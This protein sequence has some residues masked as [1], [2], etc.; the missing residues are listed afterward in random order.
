[1][2]LF[3]PLKKGNVLRINLITLLLGILGGVMPLCAAQLG[4]QWK[5]HPAA[6]LGTSA[7]GSQVQKM[8]ATERY[9]YLVTRGRL[10]DRSKGGKN[11][12]LT[13]EF[14]DL[15]RIDRQH[16]EK[17]LYP[18]IDEVGIEPRQV[19]IAE[20]SARARRLVVVYTNGAIDIVDDNDNVVKCDALKNFILPYAKGVRSIN[21]DADGSTM[22]LGLECGYFTIDLLSGQRKSFTQTATA[23][24]Y[25]NRVGTH[26]VAVAVASDGVSHL[27]V[28]D[29]DATLHTDAANAKQVAWAVKHTGNCYNTT[30][31]QLVTPQNIFPLS[32]DT[33]AVMV[34]HGSYYCVHAVK[35]AEDDSLSAVNVFQQSLNTTVM[36]ANKN[37]CHLFTLDGLVSEYRD[38]YLFNGSN[39]IGL[40]R[41]GESLDISVADPAGDYKTRAAHLLSKNGLA[42][43]SDKLDSEALRKLASWDGTS[44]DFH[45]NLVGAY[46]RAAQYDESVW[47]V[48]A[49][50]WSERSTTYALAG[51][52]NA[53]ASAFEY[54]P[55][56]GMIVR[57]NPG[58]Q[59]IAY[60]GGQYD[61]LTIFKDNKWQVLD[62]FVS[63]PGY[64]TPVAATRGVAADPLNP[65]YIYSSSFE[66]GIIRHN[67]ANRD[68]LLILSRQGETTMANVPGYIAAFPKQDGWGALVNP[69]EPKF[70]ANGV[71][72]AMYDRLPDDGEEDHMWLYYWTPEDRM[73]SLN[74]AADHSEYEN[75]P[76]KRIE[77]YKGVVSSRDHH[78]TPLMSDGHTS[79]LVYHYF[80]Y[81]KNNQ[82]YFIYDHRGT[83]DDTSDDI[84]YDLSQVELE[85][86]GRSALDPGINYYSLG[87]CE[88][89]ALGKLYVLTI[90]GCYYLNLDELEAGNPRFH[91]MMLSSE[92]YT[93]PSQANNEFTCMDIDAFG[94]RWIGTLRGLLCVDSD[95]AT[96][97]GHYTPENSGLPGNDIMTVAVNPVDGSIFVAT[98]FDGLAQFFP[99]GASGH[100][101]AKSI[102][103]VLPSEV[104]P[105]YL[106][107]VNIGGL[108]DVSSYSIVDEKGEEVA[109]LGK[110]NSGYLQWNQRNSVGSL[111]PTGA[112]FLRSGEE[113]IKEIKV[114]R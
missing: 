61:N 92:Q 72:W 2:H 113:N 95:D 14:N 37:F 48:T 88:D 78:L 73:A 60:S 21:F 53:I 110:P 93:M 84:F 104:M 56:Y 45:Y 9:T 94:R 46:S 50:V 91:Q 102:V 3:S 111:V 81:N 30:T 112:Y 33:F 71:M 105:H 27:F 97:L 29:K 54:N 65:D 80:D 83:L 5:Y 7:P 76:L 6:C 69:T 74:A 39:G 22:Y 18:V 16:P 96:L 85:H 31:Q 17:G 44:F 100:P 10:L 47:N 40:L 57:G 101:D 19:S 99:E 38:G 90:K 63:H 36:G 49:P 4:G 64:S 26:M 42:S 114:L 55:K 52:A 107:H 98:Y 12:P 51:N 25:V 108:S 75:H 79:K 89:S 34:P 35:I 87:I 68:D 62:Y 11:I 20:Y 66:H 59:K 15:F 41:R 13:T 32:D 77:I 67:L 8:L 82:K 109:L 106:G 43:L 24:D 1:M 23:I 103:S 28:C 86:T 70:D 58:T